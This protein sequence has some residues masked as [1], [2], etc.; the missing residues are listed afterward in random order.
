MTGVPS[1]ALCRIAITYWKQDQRFIGCTVDPLIIQRK[2]FISMYLNSTLNHA[3]ESVV[4]AQRMMASSMVMCL[5]H[6]S[7]D[8][9]WIFSLKKDAKDTE[10]FD[11]DMCLIKL[12]R[13]RHFRKA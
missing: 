11:D 8:R 2:A 7:C 9:Q 5:P 1:L 6:L 10:D 12:M 13:T 3:L 4:N